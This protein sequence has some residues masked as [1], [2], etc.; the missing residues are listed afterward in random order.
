MLYDQQ[1]ARKVT[2]I[3]SDVISRTMGG[4]GVMQ[5]A[6]KIWMLPGDSGTKV[7]QSHLDLLKKFKELELNK[8]LNGKR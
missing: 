4:K 2:L 5:Y 8:G 6:S 1:I 7:K 3:V